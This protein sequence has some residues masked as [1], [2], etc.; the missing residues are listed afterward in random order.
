MSSMNKRARALWL[1]PDGLWDLGTL[2]GWWPAGPGH[3]SALARPATRHTNFGAWCQ[4]HPGQACALWLSAWGVHELVVDPSLPLTGD[5]ALL[6]YAQPL[7]A[8]YYGDAAA[9]WSLTPW[10]AAGRRGVSALHGWPLPILQAQA[11]GAG[12]HLRSVRPWWCQALA[13]AAQRNALLMRADTA[14]LLVVEGLL[15]S[16]LDLRKGALHGLVQRRLAA[17]TQA[18]LAA[19]LPDNPAWPCLALGHGLQALVPT[20]QAG[21]TESGVMPA[22]PAGLTLLD[23]LTGDAPAVH[24]W[25][26]LPSGAAHQAPGGASDHAAGHT[27]GPVSGPV[28]GHAPDS[29]LAA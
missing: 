25:H 5:S 2:P 11:R 23:P 15:V 12:V 26:G 9:D 1:G 19:L 20:Q 6:A 21:V 4:A 24:W 18:A 22:S 28:S 7:L 29:A 10:Q 8:H 3:D 16:V 17:P 27:A 14:R 13:M